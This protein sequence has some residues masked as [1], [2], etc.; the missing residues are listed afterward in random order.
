MNRT[1]YNADMV[2]GFRKQI[3]EHV[4]PLV[5]KLKQRQAK[6]IGVD[7]L[8]YYDES[9]EFQTGNATPKGDAKWIIENGKKMYTELSQETQE[10]FEFMLNEQLMDLVAMKGKE[11]GG[12][13]TYLPDYKAPFIFSNF[14]GTSGDIDVLTHE[15]GHAFQVYRSRNLSIPEYYWPTFEACEIHSMSME[16]I[17]WPWM[18]LLFKEDTDKYKFSHLSSALIFLPYGVTVDEYQHFVYEH[19]EATPAERKQAWRSIELKYLPHRNYEGNAFLENGGYW[20]TQGHIYNSPFYYIDYVLAQICAF[21]FWKRSIENDPSAW[22]DYLQLC[23]LGGSKSF[24]ELAEAAH[25]QSPFK[26]GTVETVVTT[27]SDWLNGID[28][29]AL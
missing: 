29:K 9:F 17:T 8:K 3:E 4:V 18:E 13:C 7:D 25:L 15:A 1:D 21:Q 11:S 16:F 27:I 19:P 5:S 26:E 12:Y 24:L 28:D 10:F 23:D 2:A 6:R 20:Q 22:N 14:N